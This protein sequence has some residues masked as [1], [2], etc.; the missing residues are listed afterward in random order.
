MDEEKETLKELTEQI[1]KDEMD[2]K[3]KEQEDARIKAINEANKKEIEKKDNQGQNKY[4][5]ILVI[6]IL[7]ALAIVG[8]LYLHFNKKEEAPSTDSP[9]EERIVYVLNKRYG[10][11][12]KFVENGVYEDSK[13]NKFEVKTNDNTASKLIVYDKYLDN[14]QINKITSKIS[15]ILTTN[16]LNNVSVTLSGAKDCRFVGVCASDQYYYDTYKDNTDETLLEKRSNELDLSKYV[17]MS[18][19]TFFNEY[20]LK[21][22]ITIKGEYNTSD[23]STIKN[24]ISELFRELNESGYQNNL[25]YDIVVKA[26]NNIEDILVLEGDKTSDKTFDLYLA[27]E[28]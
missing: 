28:S 4:L 26:K 24:V 18:N 7:L 12:F 3:L 21:I 27:K 5:I 19:N 23:I 22:N 1:N 17:S 8:G 11:E 15:N 2:R 16:G 14:L 25:G 6:I 9:L 20:G 13:G 10:D